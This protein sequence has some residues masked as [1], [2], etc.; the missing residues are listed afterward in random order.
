M[1][2]RSPFRSRSLLA[3]SLPLFALVSCQGPE[4]RKEPTQVRGSLERLQTLQPADIAVAP[5]RDQTQAQRVP[6]ELF[7]SAFV[8]ALVERRYS[9]L[10]P[11]YVDGNWVESSF[12]GTPPPDG[13]LVVAITSWDPTHIYSTG[14]VE[15]AAELALFEGGDTTGKVLW[16]V[17]L[18]RDLYLGPGHGKPPA[19]GV[20]LV[21][22]AVRLFAQQAL[23]EL[24]MRDP[25]AAHT[26]PAG[27]RR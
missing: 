22:R 27:S 17:T 4:A 9:P 18:A 21:P 16:Q 5:I 6:Q 10:A 24:P 3:L 23:K 11:A 14:I 20:D 13:V 1:S 12:R 25:V 26:P 19:P 8:E 15:A 2:A 7:R